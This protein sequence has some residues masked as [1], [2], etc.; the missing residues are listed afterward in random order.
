LAPVAAQEF[1]SALAPFIDEKTARR[2]LTRVV[3]EGGI[4]LDDLERWIVRASRGAGEYAGIHHH[5]PGSTAIAIA[6]YRALELARKS[7]VESARKSA[8]RNDGSA[9]CRSEMPSGGAERA[10]PPPRDL[11]S[12]LDAALR[13]GNRARPSSRH[14]PTELTASARL[15]RNDLVPSGARVSDD[16][17]S[18]A[19]GPG[20]PDNVDAGGST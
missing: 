11:L 20:G 6:R 14:F 10:A 2:E 9:T 5:R 4:P 12:R 8:K 16:E 18:G 3:L 19:G 13:N 17:T 1:S 7:A 15:Q